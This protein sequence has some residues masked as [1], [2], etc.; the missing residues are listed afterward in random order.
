VGFCLYGWTPLQ[1]CLFG[2]YA[3]LIDAHHFLNVPT[4]PDPKVRL[5]LAMADEAIAR[6]NTTM[7]RS[8][9]S[10][11]NV[12]HLPFRNVTTTLLGPT[13]DELH[14]QIG[15]KNPSVRAA[16]PLLSALKQNLLVG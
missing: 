14:P 12:F 4:P 16:S 6:T 7:A 10:F 1:V 15:R 13:A 3:P 11:F 9:A 8:K 2:S 5:P